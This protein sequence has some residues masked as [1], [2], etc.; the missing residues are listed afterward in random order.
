MPITYPRAMPPVT[1]ASAHLRLQRFQT[2]TTLYGGVTQ[3]QE[4]ADPRW[5][6]DM[7]TIPLTPTQAQRLAAWI[8]SLRGGLKTFL[9]SH[10]VL[11]RPA[12]YYAGL[13]ATRAAGG[14]FDGTASVSALTDTTISLTGLP[15]SLVLGAGDRIGLTQAGRYGLFRVLQDVT[16]SGGGAVTVDVEPRVNA[17]LFTTAAVARLDQP[18]V[19]MFLVPDSLP[20]LTVSAGRSAATLS[21][22]QRVY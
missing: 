13:P 15:A 14:A 22:I 2:V 5:F 9:A 17:S 6:L 20:D 3:V 4:R 10:P 12:A 19:E 18:L 16:G 8:D 21:A 1:L 7:T 11:C